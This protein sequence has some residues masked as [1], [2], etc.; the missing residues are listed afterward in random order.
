KSGKQ[1]E[2]PKATDGITSSADYR[3][4]SNRLSE[5]SFFARFIGWF[6]VSATLPFL[7]KGPIAAATRKRRNELNAS[8]LAGLT[9]VS[10]FLGWVLIV[11]LGYGWA[12]VLL[13]VVLAAGMGWYNHDAIDYIDRHLA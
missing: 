4:L 11:S 1:R 9:L 7:L 12:S 2:L 10:V 8:V 6:A 13:L 3:Y 5:M